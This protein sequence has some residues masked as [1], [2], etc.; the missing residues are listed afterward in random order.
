MMSIG[1]TLAI[2]SGVS[3]SLISTAALADVEASDSAVTK[4]L[5]AVHNALEIAVGAG[6]A[7]GTG[8]IADNMA[9][10]GDLSGAG[11]T[12]ELKIG[13]RIIP[14]LAIGAYGTLAA[15]AEGDQVDNS[16]VMGATAGVFADWHILPAEELDPWIGLS[17]GWR[18]LWVDP[19]SG[20]GETLQGLELARLQVGLDYRITPEVA[21][22]P[23]VGGALSMFVAH[24]GPGTDGYDEIDDQSVGVF[25]FGGVQGRF[26]L[27][28]QE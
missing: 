26:D 15:F 5:G 3:V 20:K 12:G 7:Q 24:D 25:F 23:V 16:N 2:V 19:D 22:A 4:R 28:G 13:Y 11:G 9:S 18:T 27:L 10:V 8:D 6:Y 17:S 14:E 21:I 1:K